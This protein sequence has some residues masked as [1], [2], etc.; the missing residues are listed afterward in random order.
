MGRLFR[1]S[2]WQGWLVASSGLLRNIRI[3]R[4]LIGKRARNAANAAAHTVFLYNHFTAHGG[5]IRVITA[6]GLLHGSKVHA[7][8][9]LRRVVTN[10]EYGDQNSIYFLQVFLFPLTLYFVFFMGSST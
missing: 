3:K 7:D 4:R 1:R 10:A 8:V 6:L 2:A 9:R 5:Q